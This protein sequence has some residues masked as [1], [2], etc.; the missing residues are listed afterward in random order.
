[1]IVLYDDYLW[2]CDGF[3]RR[4]FNP[5]QEKQKRKYVKSGRYA[6]KNKPAEEKQ[7]AILPDKTLQAEAM[8]KLIE[9]ISKK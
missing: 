9:V 4:P 5:P 7:Q 8:H 3:T 6:K 1:M 2:D